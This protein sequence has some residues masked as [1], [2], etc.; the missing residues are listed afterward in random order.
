MFEVPLE[1][2]AHER[3]C[4]CVVAHACFDGARIFGSE[5]APRAACEINLV[6]GDFPA[7]WKAL[8]EALW[9]GRAEV[10]CVAD[11][12][13]FCRANFAGRKPVEQ[14]EKL[15]LIVEVVLEP[16]HD[17]FM[18]QGS[19]EG[20]VAFGEVAHGFVKGAPAGVGDEARA[21]RAELIE[22]DVAWH[23]AVVQ[24]VVPRQNLSGEAGGANYTCCGAAIRDVEQ[25]CRVRGSGERGAGGGQR[26][27]GNGQ[28]AT[29]TDVVR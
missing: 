26:A 7:E 24:D 9:C 20:A 12:G 1:R 3:E 27:T 16:Q 15:K 28:R 11:E 23:G 25:G 10:L 18:A 17:F 4:A 21:D 22:R 5:R 2:G 13:Q 19:F 6:V 8:G 29:V 14:L